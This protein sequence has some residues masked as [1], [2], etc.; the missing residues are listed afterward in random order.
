VRMV[1]EYLMCLMK[2]SHIAVAAEK[3]SLK[4]M[5]SVLTKLVISVHTFI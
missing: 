3:Y 1:G 2:Q 5:H 4:F